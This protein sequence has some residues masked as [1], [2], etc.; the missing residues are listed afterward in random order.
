MNKS[1]SINSDDLARAE[2]AAK[3]GGYSARALS[4]DMNDANG[5]L[6]ALPVAYYTNG[7]GIIEQVLLGNPLRWGVL[8][9]ATG[10]GGV[11]LGTDGSA[12]ALQGALLDV[13]QWWVHINYRQVGPLVCLPWY[14]YWEPGNSVLAVIEIIVQS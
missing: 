6:S 2:A 1:G 9:A 10:V 7:A 8:F 14:G 13:S 5:Q 4:R 11:N 3:S 12:N